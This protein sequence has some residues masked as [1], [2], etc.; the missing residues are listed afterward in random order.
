MI[1]FSCQCGK[2]LKAPEEF[3]GRQTR[4]PGCGK[5]VTVPAA[6]VAV[7]AAAPPPA[8]PNLAQAVQSTS[9]TPA[10]TSANP[11]HLAPARPAKAHRMALVSL[12]LALFSLVLPC[13]PVIP[14][15]I[16]DWSDWALGL[17]SMGMCVQALMVMAAVGCGIFGLVAINKSQGAVGG[18]GL[19]IAGIAIA[20]ASVVIW[21][22]G[23][24][25][26]G[27][28]FV[29]G[30]K[31]REAAKR[32]E[33]HKNL[34]Q[35]GIALHNYHD[36]F[37]TFPSD[38]ET[39]PTNQKNK[40]SW[41]VHILPFIEQDPLYRQ[42]KLDEPWDGPNNIKLLP[43][44]PKFYRDPRFPDP[45]PGLTY[46][47]SFAGPNAILNTPGGSNL[48]A[49]TNANGSSNTI[50]VVEAGDPGEWT[51]P[52]DLSL[53][54]GKPFPAFGGPKR[55]PFAALFGDGHVQTLPQSVNQQTMRMMVD[56]T[57]TQSFKLP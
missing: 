39:G 13:L 16:F 4:C 12:A 2:Q 24:V 54:P 21:A 45:G 53:E 43:Q 51:K 34:H 41:R 44:M 42:F 47:R 3:V 35:I 18:K 11:F 29:A 25:G 5:E 33:S 22:I 55:I 8:A 46:Y 7:Q 15:F 30:T 6:D 48:T 17:A 38:G 56:W 20:A 27:L 49:I 9:T 50:M 52:D 28:F 57:N 14:A 19:A 31:S 36:T 37:G 23:G 10:S 32:I 26:F 40:L 1:T